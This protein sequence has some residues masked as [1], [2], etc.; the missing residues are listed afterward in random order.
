MVSLVH[1]HNRF[2]TDLSALT[3]AFISNF[4]TLQLPKWSLKYVNRSITSMIKTTNDFYLYPTPPRP[5]LGLP[6]SPASCSV[7]L[8]LYIRTTLA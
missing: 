6:A 5:N 4:L 7:R 8:L 3:L 1:E 2:L